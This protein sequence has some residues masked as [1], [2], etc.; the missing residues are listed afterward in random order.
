MKLA[1]MDFVVQPS[2]DDASEITSREEPDVYK[3]TYR[4]A[5]LKL[6]AAM[7]A[8]PNLR[9][10][11]IALLTADT[12]VSL[13]GN[14]LGKPADQKAATQMLNALRGR[15]HEVNTTVA[16]T[17]SPYLEKGNIVSHTVVS[18]VQMRNYRDDEVQTYI[19]T[20]MPFD[21]AGAY[22]VQDRDFAP[23][24]SVAGCYLNVIGLPLCALR[25]LLPVA[26]VNFTRT[27]IYATCAAH[28]PQNVS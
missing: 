5:V 18:K 15:Q 19:A 3:L 9:S 28:E 27:H 24:E 11:K 7:D 1:E 25:A 10:H 2:I 16:M 12:M 17:Y 22:G 14:A 21:R 4:N 20:G 26:A 13:D 6:Q 23:A 8:A